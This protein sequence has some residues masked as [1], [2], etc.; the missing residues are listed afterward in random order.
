MSDI[1]EIIDRL[2]SA[3]P[4]AAR[5]NTGIP[6]SVAE[7]S[8]I[9]TAYRQQAAELAELRN[10]NNIPTKYVQIEGA[11]RHYCVWG[12]SSIN[13]YEALETK[14]AELREKNERLREERDI[15]WQERDAAKEKLRKLEEQEPA[16]WLGTKLVPY[17]E[18]V[19]HSSRDLAEKLGYSNNLRGYYALPKPAPVSVPDGWKEAAIAWE[20]C[21]SIHRE[22]AK[23]KDALYTTRQAD[24]V[25]HAENARAMLA[26]PTEEKE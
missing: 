19:F 11:G 6:A 16:I 26:A 7:I 10:T 20:V 2:E 18:R 3:L 14:L 17:E 1:T 25:K 21:A 24:F 4:I 22:W 8:A 12:T 15:F 9:L 5:F 23:G 13:A